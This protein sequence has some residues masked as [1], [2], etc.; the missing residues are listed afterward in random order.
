MCSVTRR[1]HTYSRMLLQAA[2]GIAFH[3]S[4]E[5][6][7]QARMSPFFPLRFLVCQQTTQSCEIALFYCNSKPVSFLRSIFFILSFIFHSQKESNRLQDVEGVEMSEI[8]VCLQFSFL[9]DAK[10]KT[11]S[12][13][14]KQESTLEAG[15]HVANPCA[16]GMSQ[17]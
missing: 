11:P 10:D 5:H 17:G 2:S 7:Q 13:F 15:P 8:E 12:E 1:P 9:L 4:R 6:R 16:Q 14:L 3:Q